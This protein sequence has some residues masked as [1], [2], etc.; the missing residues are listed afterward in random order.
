MPGPD[1]LEPV[2]IAVTAAL[3]KKAFQVVCLEVS[4]LTSVADFFV[5]CSAASDRQIGAVVDEV[6]SRLRGGGRRPLHVE[7]EGATG[8]VLL[9]YG[10]FIVH[11]FTEDRR[12]YYA[13]DSLWG[14]APRLGPEALGMADGDPTGTA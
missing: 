7:G 13:L 3:D 14:D 9:D 5:L 4:E 1:L 2:R 8:W 11:V 6:Q 12:G 10:D